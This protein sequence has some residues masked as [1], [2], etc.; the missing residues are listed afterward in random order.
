[1]NLLYHNADRHLA[2]E[3]PHDL[4]REEPVRGRHIASPHGPVQ[5]QMEFPYVSLCAKPGLYEP[6][7]ESQRFEDKFTEEI[8]DLDFV[9]CD[10]EKGL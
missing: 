10:P 5:L 4:A 3:S 2:G 9:C 1:M 6:R 8:P 7:Q